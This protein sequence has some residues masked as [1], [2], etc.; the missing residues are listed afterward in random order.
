MLNSIAS[1]PISQLQFGLTKSTLLCLTNDICEQQE[2]RVPAS[3]V[4]GFG[5]SGIFEGRGMDLSFMILPPNMFQKSFE[6]KHQ[7][8]WRGSWLYPKQVELFSR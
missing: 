5:R 7:R 6:Y 2:G 1:L 4:V 3:K 8:S